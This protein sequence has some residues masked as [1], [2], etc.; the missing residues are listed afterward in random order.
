MDEQGYKAIIEELIKLVDEGV[1]VVDSDG[2]GLYYNEQ[3]ARHEQIN[4]EDVVG[5]RFNLAFPGVSLN[6]STMYQALRKGVATKN[7]QQTYTNLYGKE[8]TTINSTVPVNVEGTT[9]AA[10][11]VAT[12][13]TNIRDMSNTIQELREDKIPLQ[14]P[15]LFL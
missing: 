9:V 4:V 6:Q 2:F 12:D 14:D 3:M 8:V 13:I 15:P 1:Y 7:K 10:I 5:K 11:E